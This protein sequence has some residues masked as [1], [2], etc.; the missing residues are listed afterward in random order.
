MD[1]AL[2]GPAHEGLSR[3][4]RIDGPV[5]ASSMLRLVV[6]KLSSRATLAVVADGKEIWRKELLVEEGDRQW[7]KLEY[8]EKWKVWQAEGAVEFRVPGPD[9][10]KHLE[11]R[12]VAGDWLAI[13]WR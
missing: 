1:G 8:L 3:P 6:G 10:V 2:L 11:L 7:D 4:L 5:T 13:G 9:D 12:T